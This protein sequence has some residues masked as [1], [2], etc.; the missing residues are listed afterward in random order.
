MDLP[1]LSAAAT[2]IL[3]GL[4]LSAASG[5]RVFLPSFLMSVGA[6]LGVVELRP[7]WMWL[8]SPFAVA[9]LGIA[10]VAELAAYAFPA[11]D[12]ALDLLAVPAAVVAGS[13][14]LMGVAGDR[15]S[16]IQWLL[17]IIGGGGVAGSLALATA[18]MRALTTVATGGIGNLSFAA[19]ETLGSLALTLG[20]LFGALALLAGLVVAGA[21]AILSRRWRARR[22]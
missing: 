11:V 18:K 1:T 5:L 6:T 22:S 16:A 12:N 19:L 8:A 9:A 7:E 4:G 10:V 17:A 13:V 2:P 15:S 14:L 3:L 21:F 20:V